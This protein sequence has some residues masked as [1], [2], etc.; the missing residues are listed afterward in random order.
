MRTRTLL[1]LLATLGAA[2]VAGCNLVLGLEPAVTDPSG[3]GP[4]GD[5]PPG[6]G[7]TDPCLPGAHDED[8]DGVADA[9][10]TCPHLPDPGQ[11]DGD[12]DGVGDACDP[13]PFSPGDRIALFL[14]FDV[15]PSGLAFEPDPLAWQIDDGALHQTSWSGAHVVRVP[16]DRA[17]LTVVTAYRIIGFEAP[18]NAQRE[19]GLL[20][21]VQ[22]TTAPLGSPHRLEAAHVLDAGVMVQILL[23]VRSHEAGGPGPPAES[24]EPALTFLTGVRYGLQLGDLGSIHGALSQ[25]GLGTQVELATSGLGPGPIG[26]RTADTAVAFEYL[27]VMVVDDP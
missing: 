9:C 21:R 14:P 3:D 12:G 25:P 19:V 24:I 26:L 27:L 4:P 13:R 22:S 2:P 8:R 15:M 18:V 1:G 6:D 17:P 20:A 10:D 5:G 7:P 11:A 16:F 23:R